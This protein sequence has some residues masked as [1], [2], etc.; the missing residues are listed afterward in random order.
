MREATPVLVPRENVNDESVTLVSWYVASGTG[1]VQ[2]QPIAQIETSKTVLEVEAPVSGVIR[3]TIG[4]GDEVAVGAEICQ[5]G[6]DAAAIEPA[7]NGE[8]P[9][10]PATAAVASTSASHAPA[11]ASGTRES[12]VDM[13]PQSTRFSR[14][15]SELIQQL[16]LDSAQFAGRGLV[17]VRDIM[18]AVDGAAARA[19]QPPASAAEVEVE[20][21][22][23]QPDRAQRAPSPSG[24]SDDP[25]VVAAVG[26]AFRSERLSRAKRT[27]ARYLRSASGSTITSAVTVACRTRGFRAAARQ[28]A[29][30][31]EN[32]TAV[33]LF[34]VARL[35]R[36]YPTF[37][38]FHTGGS[39][40]YYDDVNIGLAVDA[41]RGLKVLVIRH[42]DRKTITEIAGEMRELLVGYLDDQ[43][44]V[45]ALAG[46]TFTVTDL[47]GEGVFAFHPLIN[48]G[49]SAILG[50]GGEVF[51]PG[52][53]EGLFNLILSFDHQ[54]SEG[55]AA[56][57]FL[58]ELRRRLECYEASL[59]VPDGLATSTEAGEACCTRCRMTVGELEPHGHFLVQTVR[60]DG[61]GRLLCTRCLRGY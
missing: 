41:G 34:E 1:V 61:T 30:I 56:A 27:E 21:A 24:G 12:A 28:Q 43:L 6:D 4:E 44:P 53:R 9:V 47:A 13:P 36:K 55:R 52:V 38:A 2:G 57:R 46:G 58:N 5:I 17:R 18:Q 16:G 37:N 23:A 14:K 33:I 32:A 35:L 10:V 42:A 19:E 26:V 11:S 15:A 25:A 22:H 59:P 39:V 60:S 51:A 40:H 31:G 49:Q 45:E 7:R 50:V 3:Y 54:L 8:R 48:Q 20:A 29:A